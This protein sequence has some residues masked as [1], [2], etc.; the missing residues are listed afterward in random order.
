MRRPDKKLQRHFEAGAAAGTFTFDVV[1]AGST[2][3]GSAR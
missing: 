2:K 3:Q 1:S